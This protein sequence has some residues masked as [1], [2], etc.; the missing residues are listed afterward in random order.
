MLNNAPLPIVSFV[1]AESRAGADVTGD[2][3]YTGYGFRPLLVF[4]ILSTS[5]MV[6][7]IGFANAT[8]THHACIYNT[9]AAWNASNDCVRSDNGAGA[10]QQAYLKSMDADGFTL[11]WTKTGAP[12]WASSIKVLAIG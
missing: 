3:A 10:R 4:F 12:G 6:A 9:G 11:S 2:V 7:S 8:P 5:T 1:K